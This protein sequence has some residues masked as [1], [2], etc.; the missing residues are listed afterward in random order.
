MPA[1]TPSAASAAFLALHRPGD[2]LLLPNAWDA[3]SARILA[4]LGFA[5]LATTSSGFAATLG[6]PDGA[7]TRD[8]TLA[9]AAALAA[10]VDVPVSADLEN[11]FGD[12][13]AD[14]AGAVTDA[15][16]AGL[17]GCSI[18]DHTGR[19]D[20]PIYDRALAVERVAAA[21]EASGG[22][23]LTARCENH[24]HG[25]G[26]LAD[27]IARLQAYQEAGADVLYAPGLRDVGQVAAL[28]REVDRPVNAL[29]VRG[30]PTPAELAD[31]GVARLS[32]GGT[33]AWNALSAL[34]DAARE[35]QAG[36]VGFLDRTGPAREVM[37][38]A[39]HA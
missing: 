13:P 22:L 38:R 33:F 4:A 18:E 12:S 27:T 9:H 10:A 29:L 26:D 6:R 15:R 34:V 37:G 28:C 8:E 25:R 36:E 17:A 14:V 16:A 1:T 39:F 23:V 35:L 21:A 24:L 31:A 3:G 32:V 2:P 30:G 19:D 11:G 5:A 7:V 20:D